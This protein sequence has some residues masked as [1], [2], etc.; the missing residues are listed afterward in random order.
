MHL[1]YIALNTGNPVYLRDKLD[2]FSTE[3]RVSIRHSHDPHRLNEP[4]M[5]MEVRTRLSFKYSA[6]KLF[7]TLPRSVKDSGNLKFFK[8]KLK[9]YLFGECYDLDTK[10]VTDT[11]H[12]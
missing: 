7:N 2:K 3:L 10:T 11:Y 4:I 6:P 9:P 8:K 1:T 5:N 12:I